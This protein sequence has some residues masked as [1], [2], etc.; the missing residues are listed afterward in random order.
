MLNQC[1]FIGRLGRDVEVRYTQNGKA[2]ANFSIAC[3]EKRKDQ[4]F[5]EWINIVAW[6]KLAEISEKYLS[7]G[8]LVYVSGKYQ[9]RKWQD[10]D[11]K[12]R[13]ATE[14]VIHDMKMLSPRGQQDGGGRGDG[15]GYESPPMESDIP[16]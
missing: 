4:E 6:D 3:T 16:F 2:V 11:G 1:N 15:G 10:N 5:T 12:D 14:I 7:K 13:Y 9:T 8:S